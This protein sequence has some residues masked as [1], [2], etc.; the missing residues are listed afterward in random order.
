MGHLVMAGRV[1]V[2]EHVRVMVWARRARRQWVRGGWWWLETWLDGCAVFETCRASQSTPSK[3]GMFHYL[4]ATES[5]Q[6]ALNSE[7]TWVCILKIKYSGGGRRRNWSGKSRRMDQRVIA[8]FWERD[9]LGKLKFWWRVSRL[10]GKERQAK[11]TW[12]HAQRHCG[13]R[14]WRWEFV[15]WQEKE[16]LKRKSVSVLSW[17][18][19]LIPEKFVYRWQTL[20]LVISSEV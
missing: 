3:E 5:Y 17:L 4:S 1:R 10:S 12:G 2:A 8:R 19:Q 7:V 9:D 16:L 13:Q 15:G 14:V 11:M 20:W 6:K 18:R